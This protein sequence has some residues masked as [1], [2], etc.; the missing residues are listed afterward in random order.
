MSKSLVFITGANSGVGLETARVF[1]TAGYPVLAISRDISKIESLNLPNLICKSVDVRNERSVSEVVA[2]TQKQHGPI[3]L[4]FANA[5]IALLGN[6][7]DQEPN[8]W[9][10]IIDTN[11]MGVLNCVNCVLKDMVKK[12]SGTIAFM[13][14]VSGNRNYKDHAIYGATKAFVS[15]FAESLHNSV[16]QFGVRSLI[17]NAGIVETNLLDRIKDKRALKSYATGKK[18]IGGG[19]EPKVIADLLLSSYEMPKTINLHELTVLPTK[20]NL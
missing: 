11:V 6:P 1:A 20:Q 2:E 3:D 10:E 12:Q 8:Q 9:K 5:G 7:V 16:N 14:S 19:L 4:L 18:W 17:I 13:G 15:S